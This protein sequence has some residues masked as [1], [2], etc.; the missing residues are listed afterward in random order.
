MWVDF[1]VMNDSMHVHFTDC[2]LCFAVILNNLSRDVKLKL[3][4]IY[5]N[6]KIPLYIY[7]ILMCGRVILVLFIQ[8]TYQ[9]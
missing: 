2:T 5:S 3:L 1:S 8:S 9:S 6:T 7:I 4:L